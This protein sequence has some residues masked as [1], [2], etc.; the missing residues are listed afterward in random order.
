MDKDR[1]DEKMLYLK[2]LLFELNEISK[3]DKKEFF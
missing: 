2:E 1:I 3:M